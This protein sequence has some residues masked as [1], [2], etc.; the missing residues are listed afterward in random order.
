MSKE[1]IDEAIEFLKKECVYNGCTWTAQFTYAGYKH[2]FAL[3]ESAKAE[4]GE[5]TKEI[6]RVYGLSS[7]RVDK[8]K[9]THGPCCTCQRCGY[10]HDECKCLDNDLIEL[11]D[12][13]DALF[14]DW[15]QLILDN[16]AQRLEINIL[17]SENHGRRNLIY[18]LTAEKKALMAA[19]E[20]LIEDRE[21]IEQDEAIGACQCLA[22]A[23]DDIL[24]PEPCS[25]CK[26][27][28]ALAEARQQEG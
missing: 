7:T 18:R 26:A 22:K 25:Y 15:E 28:T 1:Q 27:K 21:L 14:L 11:C 20:G 17:A 19:C 24:E 8:I 3:L 16:D 12:R 13:L 23:P 6:R 9:P 2:L 4:P 10:D 5:F